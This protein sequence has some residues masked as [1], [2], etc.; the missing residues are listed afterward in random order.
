MVLRTVIFTKYGLDEQ[1]KGYGM[2]GTYGTFER[3]RER[4]RGGKEEGR[5]R[6]RERDENCL[7]YFNVTY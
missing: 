3:E 5:G 2:M 6:E 1:I 4:E 7:Q